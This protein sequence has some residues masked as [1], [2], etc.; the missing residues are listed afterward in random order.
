[1]CEIK[2]CQSVIIKLESGM[3]KNAYVN[4][5]VYLFNYLFI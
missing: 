3:I 4:F 1:M 5:L 2:F